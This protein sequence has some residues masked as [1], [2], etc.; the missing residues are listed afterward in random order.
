MAPL[1]RI[2]ALWEGYRPSRRR[3]IPWRGEWRW[4]LKDIHLEVAS[5][6]IV[7]V[8]GKNGSGKT[9]LLQSVAGVLRPTRGA[10][11]V[12]RPVASL[13]DLS[14]GFHR[15]LT[16]HEN[17]L[18]GGVLLGL[19]RAQV[20]ARYDDIVEF[21]GV[22]QDALQSP[23]STFSTGMGLR[24]GFALIVHSEPRVLVVDEV[25]AVGDEAF[26]TR[27][28]ARVEEMVANGCA[29]VMASHD[30]DLV[31]DHCDRVMVLHD[32]EQIFTGPVAEGLEHYLAR[33][34]DS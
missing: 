6:E 31:A 28:I 27:C 14:A 3:R 4:A 25:L 29:M 8:V 24:L 17:L 18:F 21:A 19:T 2:E 16:G 9:T 15:D 1:V 13:V 32:G 11:H 20:R 26:Q 33:V 5:G 30:L 22:D 34:Q 23:L 10:V 7:G 12:E